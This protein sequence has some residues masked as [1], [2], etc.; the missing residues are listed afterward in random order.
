MRSPSE[1]VQSFGPMAGDAGATT[2]DA[3]PRTPQLQRLAAPWAGARVP[4]ADVPA[5][6]AEVFRAA[7]NRARCA[8]LVPA[9]LGEGGDGRPRADRT[10][11]GWGVAYDLAGERGVSRDG[12]P[13]ESCGRAV[14]GIAGT[15]VESA[16]LS[17]RRAWSDG[18][19]ADYG[20]AGG[21]DAGPFVAHLRLA[22]QECVYRLWS[23][24]GRDHLE[25]LLEH[26]QFVE[27]P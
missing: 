6:F 14:F 18:S 26:L 19:H 15:N 9:T 3:A 20:R 8:L 11:G 10:P 7:P 1:T 2:T 27:A 13:C 5:V 4:I 17:L 23:H 25:H 16:A 21:S 12:T 22:G 24:L